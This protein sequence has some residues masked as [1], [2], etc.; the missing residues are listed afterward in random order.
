[1]LFHEESYNKWTS[2]IKKG[3]VAPNRSKPE[4]RALNPKGLYSKR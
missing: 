2:A 1:M 4:L 3:A